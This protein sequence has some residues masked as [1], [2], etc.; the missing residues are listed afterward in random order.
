GMANLQVRLLNQTK[1][2][3]GIRRRVSL[4]ETWYYCAGKTTLLRTLVGLEK[5]AG[6]PDRR[7]W[8][9]TRA[10]QRSL[11]SPRCNSFRGVDA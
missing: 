6:W 8:R 2:D 10:V 11:L 3:S 1:A 5:P 9:R 7:L 4:S